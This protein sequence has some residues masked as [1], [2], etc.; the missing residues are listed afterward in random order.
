MIIP[1]QLINTPYSPS[2]S[3]LQQDQ[4]RD[5]LRKVLKWSFRFAQ[6]PRKSFQMQIH[7]QQFCSQFSNQFFCV[8]RSRLRHSKP[9]SPLHSSL[10]VSKFSVAF[11]KAKCN[12]LSQ[13]L[14]QPLFI[15]TSAIAF[16]GRR[17]NTS[18][19]LLQPTLQYLNFKGFGLFK[20]SNSRICIL[21]SQTFW[22]IILKSDHILL[23]FPLTG[24]L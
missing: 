19:T 2:L 8:F 15:N 22:V 4:P 12:Y 10:E 21:R 11:F 17:K 18:N 1:Y 14:L 13:S 20:G 9:T 23:K 24:I 7:M 5:L 3:G 16:K 6:Q